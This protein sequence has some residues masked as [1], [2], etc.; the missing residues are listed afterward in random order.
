MNQAVTVQ[1]ITKK[2][3]LHNRER[4][5]LTALHDISLTIPFGMSLGVIGFNGSGKTTLLR[6]IAGLLAPTSGTVKIHS[7]LL[8]FLDLGIGFNQELT[9]RQNIRM[10]GALIGNR[11]H[12]V[13]YQEEILM[14][15]ELRTF[16]DTLFRDLSAGMQTRVA[17]ATVLHTEATIFIFDEALAVGDYPFRRRCIDRLQ[18]LRT[19]GKTIIFTSHNMELVTQLADRVAW[20]DKGALQAIGTP[21]EIVN[22]YQAASPDRR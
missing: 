8:A 2:F 18:L 15:A 20:L 21:S 3:R 4:S 19:Q 1:S 12:L 6:I 11:D 5:P 22:L 9:L 7:T 10:Y 17:M 14:F 13:A 16:A